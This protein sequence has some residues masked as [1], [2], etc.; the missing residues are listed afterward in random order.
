MRGEASKLFVFPTPS[1]QIRN[2]AQNR[3]AASTSRELVGVVPQV[4]LP[5][6]KDSIGVLSQEMFS[7][8]LSSF[9]PTV[10]ARSSLV[11]HSWR[12]SILSTP[13]LHTELDLTSSGESSQI[14]RLLYDFTRLSALSLNSLIRASFD[15]SHFAREFTE[16]IIELPNSDSLT[17]LELF[18]D[19]LQ[20][21]QFSLKEVEFVVKNNSDHG[22]DYTYMEIVLYLFNNL[23]K[24]LN[25]K[26]TEMTVPLSVNVKVDNGKPGTKKANIVSNG[27]TGTKPEVGTL[28]QELKNCVR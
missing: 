22:L 21:S 26:S 17:G 1:T 23:K 19:I 25:L 27:G 11:C 18:S 13:S 24:F 8:V 6:R 10:I 7:Q 3:D 16:N 15:I 5:Q 20:K 4:K 28:V 9:P 2:M 12:T 14:Y